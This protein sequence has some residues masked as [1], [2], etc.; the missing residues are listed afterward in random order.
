MGYGEESIL[1]SH[2]SREAHKDYITA[3][4]QFE[5]TR[6]VFDK[7]HEDVAKQRVGQEGP[8]FAFI[9]INAKHLD[10]TSQDHVITTDIG[11]IDAQLAKLFHLLL[12]DSL[13][14]VVTQGD[15]TRMKKLSARKQRSRW[16][17][18]KSEQLI[19]GIKPAPWTE[20]DEEELILAAA[21]AIAGGVFLRVKPSSSTH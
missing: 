10:Q 8:H 21:D 11:Y 20:A 17:T 15:I 7:V 3:T 1:S 6:E 9:E 5:R 16:E 14:M 2:A 19:A 18:T 4:F 12:P 13:L